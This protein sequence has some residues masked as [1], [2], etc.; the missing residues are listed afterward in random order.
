[1]PHADRDVATVHGGVRFL[2]PAAASSQTSRRQSISSSIRCDGFRL[3]MS[4][5]ER[6]AI[7]TGTSSGLGSAIAQTL[8]AQGWTVIGMSRRQPD[9]AAP[10][11]RHIGIDLG[12]LSRLRE[13][14]E[15]ELGPVLAE[16]KWSRIGLVNNAGA[17]GS[18]HALEQADPLQVASV[19]A[20]NTL[21]PIFRAGLVV[22][23]APQAT[24]LR[25]V[26][27]SSGAAV[28]PIPGI[29]DYGSS[30]A[31]LRLASMTFAAE[32]ASSERPGGARPNVL[33]LSYAPGIVD[34][35]MQEAA[36]ADD[37]P[38]NRLFVDF[39]AQ[40]KLVPADAPAREVA[41]FLSCE[42]EKPFAERRFGE[43]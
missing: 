33:I 4:A 6:L 17:V 27:V 9:F 5:N 24:P 31:A 14:A 30:K 35:P 12:D 18:M 15:R 10:G 7:V 32:L 41:E 38:W 29:G 43:P 36:R 8:L 28:Q 20:V 37:R 25:I 26:N 11:Y 42:N 39:H 13:V 3:N 22:R 1:V 34:T 40:G 23:N 16:P 19:F 21:T 2:V